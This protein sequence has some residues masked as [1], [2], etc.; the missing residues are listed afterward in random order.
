MVPFR[1]QKSRQR[2]EAS[3]RRLSTSSSSKHLIPFALANLVKWRELMDGVR[4]DFHPYHPSSSD[5][6]HLPETKISASHAYLIG[7]IIRRS[8]HLAWWTHLAPRFTDEEQ[9]KNAWRYCSAHLYHLLALIT[10]GGDEQD[11]REHVSTLEKCL[12]T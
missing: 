9:A 4:I 5:M 7:N 10:R 12:E 3:L 6:D 8:F 1:Y 2:L 11:V